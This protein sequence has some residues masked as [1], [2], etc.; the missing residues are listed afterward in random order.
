MPTNPYPRE[1]RTLLPSQMKAVAALVREAG[2]PREAFDFVEPS[3]EE[4][5]YTALVYL[6]SPRYR[7]NFYPTSQ[8]AVEY[9]PADQR[10][11][12]WEE[13]GNWDSA[14]IRVEWWLTY[15][16]RELGVGDPWAEVTQGGLTEF[17]NDPADNSPLRADEREK[18]IARIEQ[19]KVYLL[20]AGVRSDQDRHA[21]IERLDYLTAATRRLG[22]FDLRALAVST[23][24]DLA[25][26]GYVERDTVKHVV[27][28]IVGAAQQL[29]R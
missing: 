3:G 19:L 8:W 16:K 11:S 23:V 22:R 26:I 17:A 2:L 29:L 27:D 9:S 28:F 25:L 10:T 12:S 13:V 7:F 24:I 15:L 6:P 21:I 4:F 5:D 18:V 1:Q 20:D 14:L